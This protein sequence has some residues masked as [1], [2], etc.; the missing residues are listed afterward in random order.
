MISI[1]K[2]SVTPC[3]YYKTSRERVRAFKISL[4]LSSFIIYPSFAETTT[5]KI[6]TD[7]L[8]E[9]TGDNVTWNVAT[10]E[11]ISA[12]TYIVFI[13]GAY[14]KYTY[15]NSKGYDVTNTRFNPNTNANTQSVV[16]KDIANIVTS[17]EA[18]G[19]AIYI[20]WRLHKLLAIIDQ[21]LK[22]GASPLRLCLKDS[23]DPFG[24]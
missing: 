5:P 3:N 22:I 7:Y 9:L 19:G 23:H 20:E 16:F 4:I 17:G 15:N 1:I 6:S 24:Q 21:T 13:N 18:L 12:G 2:N 8:N 11:E 14:Y 10:E